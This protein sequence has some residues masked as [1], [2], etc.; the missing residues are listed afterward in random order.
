MGTN[1][2]GIRYTGIKREPFEVYLDDFGASRVKSV[3]VATKNRPNGDLYVQLPAGQVLGK[4]ASGDGLHY[5]LA[6]AECQGDISGTTTIP[7]GTDDLGTRARMFRQGDWVELPESVS[8]GTD[9]FRQV[10]DVDFDN[11]EI[12]VDGS[13]F[14]LSD[15]DSIE[16]DPT[17]TFQTVQDS[18]TNTGDTITVSDASHYAAGDRVDVGPATASLTIEMPDGTYTGTASIS[19]MVDDDEGD[20]I[21]SVTAEFDASSDTEDTIMQDLADQIDDALSNFDEGNLGS[22]SSSAGPPATVEVS[23]A[24]PDY[25]FRYTWSD[26]DVG[27]SLS[28]S[29]DDSTA[30]LVDSVD[31]N[32]DQITLAKTITFANGELVVSDRDG[33]Y[34]IMYET[35]ELTSESYTPQNVLAP[36]RDRG[37]VREQHVDGLT[38]SAREKLAGKLDFTS[39]HN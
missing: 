3:S 25:D 37:E 13:D 11:D 19:L 6:Y 27:T 33:E 32:N 26:T 21:F 20:E 14:S 2:V 34:K 10:T 31:E 38:P 9:R 28:A 39:S 15:G 8:E 36:Y 22:A 16:V 5:P 1:A 12:T 4:W 7:V 30:V 24:D 35:V 17:R 29:E 18:G 23:L